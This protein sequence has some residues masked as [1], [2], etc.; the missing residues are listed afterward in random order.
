MGIEVLHAPRSCKGSEYCLKVARR[1]FNHRSS[2][3]G[4]EPSAV[5]FPDTIPYL[6]CQGRSIPLLSFA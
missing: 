4:Y 3:P 1:D 2:F 5:K 6:N